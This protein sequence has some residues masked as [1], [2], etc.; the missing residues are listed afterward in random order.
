MLE[1]V[2]SKTYDYDDY[3]YGSASETF[4]LTV[5]DTAGNM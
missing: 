5:S 4:T 1:H 3:S 2:F